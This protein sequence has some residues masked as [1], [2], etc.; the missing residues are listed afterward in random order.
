[1]KMDSHNGDIYAFANAS[2]TIV[3]LVQYDKNGASLHKK[4]T[5]TPVDW[6]PYD[7]K[8]SVLEGS[9]AKQFLDDIK[10]PKGILKKPE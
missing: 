9:R 5:N 2:Q 1:M 8:S 4:H 6:P 3:K 7:G 10:L